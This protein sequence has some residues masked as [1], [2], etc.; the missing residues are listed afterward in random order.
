[1]LITCQPLRP[2]QARGEEGKQ[3]LQVLGVHVEP[4]VLGHGGCD[5]HGHRSRQ[6]RRE[7]AELAGLRGHH[8]TTHHQL[9]K[10]FH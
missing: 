6:W 2:Q 4:A 7:A 1:M 9:N 3:V 5:N 8:H 10:Q